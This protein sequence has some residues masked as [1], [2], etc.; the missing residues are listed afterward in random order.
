MAVNTTPTREQWPPR[1]ALWLSLAAAPTFAIMALLTLVPGG[2]PDPLCSASS[3]LNG[4]AMM[5]LLM[6][7]FHS[8]PWLKL[9]CGRHSG[10]RIKPSP[11]ALGMRH[12]SDGPLA[13]VLSVA[14]DP[15]GR[16]IARNLLARMPRQ[17]A[18]PCVSPAQ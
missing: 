17:T 9:V 15:L 12:I 8:A 18:S 4:M 13:V 1:A 11:C 6:S 7:A 14:K 2:M 10:A 16:R 5:Y 3:P